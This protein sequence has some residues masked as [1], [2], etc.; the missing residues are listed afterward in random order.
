MTRFL[1]ALSLVGSAPLC[2]SIGR[3]ARRRNVNADVDILMDDIDWLAQYRTG[4]D[5]ASG[6]DFTAIRIRLPEQANV[7][8]RN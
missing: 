6:K 4:F 2:A 5:G 1:L 8:W 3:W 7:T